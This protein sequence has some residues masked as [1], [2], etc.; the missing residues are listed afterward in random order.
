[1]NLNRS[2]SALAGIGIL[3]L[4]ACGADT[5]SNSSATQASD[6]A[7]TVHRVIDG[8]TI[9]VNDAGTTK[10]VRLLNVD[11]P[12]TKHPNKAVQ[13][14]GPEASDFLTNLL[15]QGTPVTLEYDVER[16]DKYGRDLA[17]VFLKDGSF[18]NEEIAQEGLGVAVLFEPNSKFYERVRSAQQDAEKNQVGLFNQS[19][20]CS[21]PARFNSMTTALTNAATVTDMEGAI[22]AAEDFLALFNEAENAAEESFSVAGLLKVS[23]ISNKREDLKALVRTVKTEKDTLAD[24]NKAATQ[25]ETDTAPQ[26]Q[27]AP[28]EPQ[29]VPTVDAEAERIAAEQAAAAQAEAE[30]VAAEQ[31]AAAQAEAERIVAEQAA[32]AQAEAERIAAEQQ[33]QQQTYTIPDPAPAPAEPTHVEQE[34]APVQE[35]Y[36]NYTGPR[37]YAPG[38]KTWKPCP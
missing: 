4:T 8:D 15:P 11:T 37:C 26:E 23:D 9:E 32:A 5:S 16:T 29:V 19:L 27:P 25:A 18:V 12:E 31:A 21:I 22:N 28:A 20:G 34:P 13:C 6:P 14:L 2:F 36:P 35:P 1:M 10:T 24:Q 33:Q 3:L 7:I 30:R 38:G 17:G